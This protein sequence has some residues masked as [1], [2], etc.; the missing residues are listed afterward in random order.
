MGAVL[1]DFALGLLGV[2]WKPVMF[3]GAGV[4]TSEFEL[5]TKLMGML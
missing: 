3:F 5:F 4:A 1:K 2:I